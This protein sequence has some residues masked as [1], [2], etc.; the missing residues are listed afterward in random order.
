MAFFEA[1]RAAASRYAAG[2]HFLGSP[3]S[4][5]SLQALA[6]RLPWPLP[7]AYRD[8]LSSFDGVTLFLEAQILFP[9]AEIR[10]VEGVPEGRSYLHIGD[11]ADGALWLDRDGRISLADDSAPDPIVVGS[12][13]EA[14]LEATLAREA[15]IVDR[16]G[17]FREVFIGDDELELGVRKK[18]AKAGQRHDPGAAQALLEQAEIA[19]E[20]GDVEA[21]QAALKQAVILDP[22]AGP[23]WGLLAALY[24][25]AGQPAGAEHAALQAAAATWHG[26][27]R[28]S[29]L[30]QAARACPSRASEHARAAWQADAQLAERLLV[31]GQAALDDAEL[32]EARHIVDQLQLLLAAASELATDTALVSQA[33]HRLAALEKQVRTRGALHVIA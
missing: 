26:P 19:Y 3:A 28:A 11:T 20:E 21:A 5:R 2:V 15:L 13:I 1:L 4:A 31:E 14:F 18:R 29:R 32:T 9:C 33:Q 23:A 12:Q 30:L 10:V 22:M 27:L 16:D 8:F 24:Q 25:A 17:E 6:G 7:T